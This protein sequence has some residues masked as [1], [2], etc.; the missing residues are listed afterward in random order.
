MEITGRE[1][2][3]KLYENPIFEELTGGSIRPGGFQLT[4]KALEYGNFYSKSKLLDLG[5]GMGA[6]VDFIQQHYDYACSGLDAS[7]LLVEKGKKKYGSLNLI[8]GKAEA[9]PFSTASFDGVLMECSFSLMESKEKV[10]Q[11]VHRTLKPQGCLMLTDMYQR[12]QE[13]MAVDG[14]A[15]IESCLMSPMRLKDLD[16]ML[17]NNGFNVELMEDETHHLHSMVASMIMTFGSAA[18]F[19]KM[20]THQPV[21]DHWTPCNSK[22]NM[23][24][25]L[26]VARKRN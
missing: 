3:I 8:E 21:D 11:E 23:G 14:N 2:R 18:D 25:F 24:Y 9:L 19:W 16:H 1:E 4:M 10:L 15:G 26:C 12:Q 5:C 6:T 20:I 22:V 7:P 13:L 17:Q